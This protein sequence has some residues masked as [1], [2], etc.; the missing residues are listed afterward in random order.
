MDNYV[1]RMA[2]SNLAPAATVT[3]P[4]TLSVGGVAVVPH[5][6]WPD[7]ATAI[8]VQS[9]DAAEVVYR[10]DG[11]AIE[12]A[13]FEVKWVHSVNSLSLPDFYWLGI[14]ISGSDTR[15]YPPPE[16]WHQENISAGQAN[17]D[18]SALMSISFDTI[19]MIRAGSIIGM[20]TR[21]SETLTDATPDSAIITV[22]VG[23]APGALFLSHSSLV[24]PDGGEVV[25]AALIDTFVAGDLIGIEITTLQSFT[26]TTTDVEAW[27]ELEF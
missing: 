20:S 15:R 3:I 4:H 27:L 14:G 23:G 8:V 26:P 24:N 18:L 2:V 11:G 13:V 1:T 7:R 12:S 22:T 10:N 5:I 25:Q 9:A 19:K 17:V 21:F 16:K 6:I